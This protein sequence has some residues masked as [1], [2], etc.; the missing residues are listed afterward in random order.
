MPTSNPSVCAIMLAN[1]RPEMVA[2]A[3]KSFRAQTFR[4]KRLL[5]YDTTPIPNFREWATRIL[6]VAWILS[7]CQRR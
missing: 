6:S 4:N 1:G 5:V 7:M 3:V 2:R